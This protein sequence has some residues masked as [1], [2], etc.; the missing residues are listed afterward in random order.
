MGEKFSESFPHLQQLLGKQRKQRTFGG[1]DSDFHDCLRSVII[2]KQAFQIKELL[3]ARKEGWL[4]DGRPMLCIMVACARLSEKRGSKPWSLRISLPD[5]REKTTGQTS[6]AICRMR[7]VSKRC[8]YNTIIGGL[9]ER[10][11]DSR[12]TWG[13]QHLK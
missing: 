10:C 11:I 9:G 6:A 1:Q 13:R 12:K 3:F 5:G 7:T 2:H 4:L 8:E